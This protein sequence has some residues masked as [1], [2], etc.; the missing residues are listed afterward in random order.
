MLLDELEG[1]IQF[2]AI[3]YPDRTI[4]RQNI[5]LE[6]TLGTFV[7]RFLS[8]GKELETSARV[9][10]TRAW[11]IVYFAYSTEDALRVM[12]DFTA[13]V[14]D[15]RLL[16]PIAN[17]LSFLRSDGVSFSKPFTNENNQDV[18]IGVLYTRT[19]TAVSQAHYEKVLNASVVIK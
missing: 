12:D 15:N 10:N 6:P 8:D 14:A 16:I 7:V 18:I 17:S 1:I 5:P 3:L 4:E 11:D 2:L 13:K 19:R 9:V